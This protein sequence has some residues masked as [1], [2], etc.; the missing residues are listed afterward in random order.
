MGE[1][2]GKRYTTVDKRGKE[3]SEGLMVLGVKILS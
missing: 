1:G 3:Y 2:K